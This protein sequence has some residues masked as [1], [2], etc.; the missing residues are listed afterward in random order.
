MRA[1]KYVCSLMYKRNGK[2]IYLKL[3]HNDSQLLQSIN[4][5]TALNYRS[6]IHFLVAI[7]FPVRNTRCNE[8]LL[9]KSLCSGPNAYSDQT[10]STGGEKSQVKGPCVYEGGTHKGLGSPQKSSHWSHIETIVL[11]GNEKRADHVTASQRNETMTIAFLLGSSLLLDNTFPHLFSTQ[12]LKTGSIIASRCLPHTLF[13][14][15]PSSKIKQC[16]G[17]LTGKST[18]HINLFLSPSLA[19][20]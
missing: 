18:S 1:R 3:T 4:R 15:L 8:I 20:S 12:C 13:N 6:C 2:P 10:T 7:H 16:W 5:N 11:D 9:C 19:G 14:I 17:L